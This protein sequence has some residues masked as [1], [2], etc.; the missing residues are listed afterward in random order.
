M[1]FFPDHFSRWLLKCKG[2]LE[3]CLFGTWDVLS[4]V[5]IRSLKI[6]AVMFASVCVEV[7]VQPVMEIQ[8]S[9]TLQNCNVFPQ[10]V[11]YLS[12]IFGLKFEMIGSL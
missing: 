9:L 8:G 12:S 6:C 1:K 11:M 2:S 3:F 5:Q 7:L 10:L 4:L